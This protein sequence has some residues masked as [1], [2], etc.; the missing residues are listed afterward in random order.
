MQIWSNKLWLCED[1]VIGW[2]QRCV[3]LFLRKPT[4][5]LVH[6]DYAGY[7]DTVS[8]QGSINTQFFF[9]YMFIFM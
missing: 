9:T 4:P 3:A 5:G 6:G 1:D 2:K 8:V 7:I